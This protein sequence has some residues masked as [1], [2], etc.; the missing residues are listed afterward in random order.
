MALS[1]KNV[2]HY[3]IF[4]ASPGDVSQER[5]VVRQ[6]FEQYNRTTA[7]QW[8]AHFDVVDWENHTTVG[9]GRPQKLITEQ[10]LEKYRASLA[11]VV[12]IMG[13][14]FGSPTGVAESGTEEEFNWAMESHLTR[15]FPEIKWFFR[16]VDKLDMPSSDPVQ[17]RH[18][19]EQW[20]KVLAFRNRMRQMNNPLFYAEYPSAAGFSEVF[21]RDLNL[22]LADPARPWSAPRRTQGLPSPPIQRLAMEPPTQQKSWR[23]YPPAEL[24]A[25]VER[26]HA[27]LAEAF[28]GQKAVRERQV[29]VRLAVRLD[30]A[31]SPR[32]TRVLEPEDLTPLLEAGG[33]QVLLLSG[34]GGA[35]KTSLAFAMA[36][37][38]LQGKPGGVVRLPVLI[39]TGLA[40]GETV[41]QKVLAW[42]SD[43]LSEPPEAALVE[44]LLRERRL[45]PILDHVSELSPEARQRLMAGL[46][47]GLVV[48]T[49]RSDDEAWPGRALRHIRPLPIALDRLQSF[50]AEYLKAREMAREMLSENACA[51]SREMPSEKACDR[52]ALL[53]DDELEQAQSRLRRIVGEKPIT[54]LLAQ[55][56]IDDV[57]ANREKGFLAESVPQLMLSYLRRLDSQTDPEQRKRAGR[58]ID[59]ALVQRALKRLALAS[60]QQHGMEGEPAYQPREFSRGLAMAALWR[61]EPDGLATTASQAQAL[62][63]YLLDQRLL[64]HPGEDTSEL[65][66]PLDPLADY[67]AALAQLEVLEVLEA[68]ERV[69]VSRNAGPTEAWE[70]F[71]ATLERRQA[72][73][74]DLSRMR[75]FL[76]ALR[77]AALGRDGRG[78]PS[79][80][81]DR[82]A[83]LG[84]LNP[85]K[86]R[87][88][89][90]EQRARKWMWELVAQQPSERRDAISKLAAMATAE[91]EA[92]RAVSVVATD[93]LIQ[94]L[95]NADLPAE[96]RE[97]AAVVLGLIASK[98]AVEALESLA[99]DGNQPPERRRMAL[100][101]LG[102]AAR[103]LPVGEGSPLRSR[104]QACLEEHLRA[105]ALDLL[106]EGDAGWAEHDRRLPVLQ[107]A[108]RGMQLAMSA[109]LPL[110]GSAPPKRV[111]MLT[112]TALKEGE[113]LR[114]RTEV[115]E[116]EVWT[117]S[118]PAVEGLAPQQLELVVVPG[119][120]YAI[121]SPEEEAGRGVYPR[122]RQNC[123]GVNVEAQRKVRMKA[124]ALV[125]HPIS[126]A[127]W[128]AV[129]ELPEAERD[130]RSS[131]ATYDARGLWERYAQPG[132][133]AVDS[134]SWNDCQEWLKRLN[135]WLS[136]Q[137]L[138]MGGQGEAP[139]FGLPSESQW[140]VACRAGTGTPFHF[141]DTLDPN[142]ANYNGDSIYGAG[143]KGI[144]RQRPV[145][146]GALGL[147]NRW[148]LAE[149]HGQ[150]WEWCADQWHRNPEE[151]AIGDGSALVGPDLG[152]EGNQEQIYRL[153]RGGSWI[154]G[155]VYARAA[156]RS[157][158]RPDSVGPDVGVRPGCFS[159]PGL[160]L[161]T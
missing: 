74:E 143:R 105:D 89:L 91:P 69:S 21:A 18:A 131:P 61:G 138:A 155:P 65:R 28:A 87:E 92:R 4:L 22:W 24:Q 149:M 82:L 2:D 96:E 43:H 6:F 104:I 26:H 147:V 95:A 33:S 101:A 132:G 80:V 111:P 30:L 52:G 31:T 41:A 125:R 63:G 83:E 56:F 9:V 120:V 107:G 78:V 51:S 157:S 94:V 39:E 134:V 55:M 160:F 1:P 47:P 109:E 54:A 58:T 59:H 156:V 45:V 64:L 70:E 10:T 133:L 35:G 126:Q 36:R 118:L 122:F 127:Q 73:G 88:R 75:G 49:S 114:I 86:E 67:L 85:E 99:R 152:L 159:P 97:E 14:R 29:H 154:S 32:E 98:E 72:K 123:K 148:G 38:W 23:D 135:R 117:L 102:L 68:L 129:A 90:A 5:Q 40:E 106:V 150:L 121:G 77:D 3:H 57:L 34:D 142:W 20:D 100:E 27:P 76:L 139:E 62:L 130:L 161:Y 81:P 44:A 25:W 50:F 113:G 84:G 112:L 124:F 144:V 158:T 16:K 115:V 137:W 42:L 11:L 141:G 119:A 79:A 136:Q 103:D 37:W 71:L 108:S 128:R 151:G 13:Q 8:N 146:V 12:G 53:R 48:A 153:L 110:L 7:H 145:P 116:P 46:P 17:C 19:L 60:H 15:G 93:R 140:E 66:F